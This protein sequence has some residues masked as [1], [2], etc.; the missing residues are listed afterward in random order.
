MLRKL[1]FGISA[2][3]LLQLFSCSAE[4]SFGGDKGGKVAV[5]TV[6]RRNI[7]ERV[8]AQGTMF[9]QTEIKVSS[10]VSGEIIQLKV[11]EGEWVNEGQLLVAI[12]PSI[13]QA[14][15]DQSQAQMNQMKA[16]LSNARARS[17]QLSAQFELAEKDYMRKQALYKSGVIAQQEFDQAESQYIQTKG[18]KE[19]AA[20]NI[21]AS[22]F[23]L[24]NATALYKQSLENLRKTKIFAPMSGTISKLNVELG[25]RVVGTAQM[26]GTELLRIS[27]LNN[28]EARVDVSENDIVKVNIGDSAE[29]E[30]ESFGDKKFRGIVTQKA[31]SS[32]QNAMITDKVTNF[33]VRIKLDKNAYKE[34]SQVHAKEKFPFRPG[35]TAAAYI[36]TEREEN[37]IAAPLTSVTLRENEKDKE[38][39]DEVVFVVEGKKAKKRIVKTG[40][41]NDDYIV[42]KDGIKEGDKIIYAPNRLLA[43]TLKDGDEVEIVPEE[44]LNKQKGSE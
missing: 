31:Y 9:S 37:M 5:D 18:E 42:V 28:M 8:N 21:N 29:I 24:E 32:N 43:K 44:K 35:M 26:S 36:I 13:Y 41:Q 25:E 12:N 17:R 15:V 16:N 3:L 34:I 23:Q 33:V 10:E 30:I 14:Q 19:A 2:V 7:E 39:S 27:D 1:F 40:I 38:K 6:K 4:F 20:E 11:K 22:T